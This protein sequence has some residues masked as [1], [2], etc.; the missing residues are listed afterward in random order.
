LVGSRAVNDA[1]GYNLTQII[2]EGSHL[3]SAH[4]EIFMP[5]FGRAY[6]VMLKYPRSVT[7]R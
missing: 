4:D 1:E 6:S 7:S 3:E 2:L 5:S